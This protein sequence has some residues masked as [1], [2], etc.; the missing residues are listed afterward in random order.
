MDH[1]TRK[2]RGKNALALLC[3]PVFDNLE[4]SLRKLH[5]SVNTMVQTDD[6]RL[7]INKH[8]AKSI[9]SLLDDVSNDVTYGLFFVGKSNI[10]SHLCY[11]QDLSMALFE[12]DT[13]NDRTLS[14]I[15]DVHLIPLVTQK[16]YNSIHFIDNF[17]DAIQPSNIYTMIRKHGDIYLGYEIYIPKTS[18]NNIIE[19]GTVQFK[20]RSGVSWKDFTMFADNSKFP[21]ILPPTHNTICRYI[22]TS[23][24]GLQTYMLK[25]QY[26]F[27]S[28]YNPQ[29]KY[30]SK[31]DSVSDSKLLTKQFKLRQYKLS[32]LNQLVVP[33]SDTGTFYELDDVSTEGC[34]RKYIHS[35]N[36]QHVSK[37]NQLSSTHKKQKVGSHPIT[38]DDL[39]SMIKDIPTETQEIDDPPHKQI[40]LSNIEDSSSVMLEDI[41]IEETQELGHDVLL[42]G[43]N[44][45]VMIQKDY[46]F[47]TPTKMFPGNPHNINMNIFSN[48]TPPMEEIYLGDIRRNACDISSSH[49]PNYISSSH[50]Y[51][52]ISPLKFRKDVQNLTYDVNSTELESL[53]TLNTQL[54]TLGEELMSC[55]YTN[56]WLNEHS[57]PMILNTTYK[58]ENRLLKFNFPKQ[59][60]KFPGD[61]STIYMISHRCFNKTLT[62]DIENE[63]INEVV[64]KIN[65][66]FI[67]IPQKNR[68]NIGKTHFIA[69]D[70]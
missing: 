4:L 44:N 19:F 48:S 49:N 28:L 9:K 42:S 23:H 13:S 10:S 6:K 53:S 70:I 52:V 66:K 62:H 29:G 39:L 46:S 21:L 67:L 31:L 16:K 35:S 22:Q 63:T 1:K 18:I 47:L 36:E 41:P 32:L 69:L 20:K 15:V 64:K 30:A 8:S 45:Q 11:Y 7:T 26:D 40:T 59:E 55:I 37:K 57:I 24:C 60:F 27:L 25:F 3:R 61:E 65:Y 17:S 43:Y 51:N 54:T 58:R 33:H 68:K 50:P 34:K 14:K 12:Y 56:I 5:F 38:D 2:I